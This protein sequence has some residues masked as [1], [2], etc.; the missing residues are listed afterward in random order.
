MSRG[1]PAKQHCCLQPVRARLGSSGL[2]AS[3]GWASWARGGHPLPQPPASVDA[4]TPTLLLT[5]DTARQAGSSSSAAAA[6][7]RC[8]PAVTARTLPA[9]PPPLTGTRRRRPWPPPSCLAGPRLFL[10]GEEKLLGSPP[11]VSRE[12][13][14]EGGGREREA[15]ARERP[16]PSAAP[17]PPLRRARSQ[18]IRQLDPVPRPRPTSG[19][20]PRTHFRPSARPR[21]TSLPWRLDG[22]ALSPVCLCP[23]PRARLRIGWAG[24][25]ATEDA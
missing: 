11:Q 16:N 18:T 19:R 17:R 3:R 5:G 23:H 4:A 21:G 13:V 25:M 2:Q 20:G 15:R 14:R 24:A 22:T 1:R 9:P 12:T 8:P 6:A 10:E 7:R